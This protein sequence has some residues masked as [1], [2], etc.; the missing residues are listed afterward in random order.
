M[1]ALF[2]VNKVIIVH[3]LSSF[4]GILIRVLWFI[5]WITNEPDSVIWSRIDQT[6]DNLGTLRILVGYKSQKI[7]ISQ[8]VKKTTPSAAFKVFR[9]SCEG[10]NI[11]IICAFQWYYIYYLIYW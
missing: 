1:R 5:A 2:R 10:Y 8:G 9:L 6:T 7:L 4:V 11:I 3:A